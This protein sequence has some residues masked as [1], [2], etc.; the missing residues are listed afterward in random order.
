MSVHV[1]RDLTIAAA[2]LAGFAIVF[3]AWVTTG[4]RVLGPE[5]WI[6]QLTFAGCFL[7]SAGYGFFMDRSNHE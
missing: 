1:K 6:V 4:A 3:I 7:F 5:M 2:I